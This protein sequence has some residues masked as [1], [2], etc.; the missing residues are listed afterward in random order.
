VWWGVLGGVAFVLLARFFEAMWYMLAG[1][2]TGVDRSYHQWLALACWTGLPQVVALAAAVPVLLVATTTQMDPGVISP[3]SLNEL[4]FHRPLG[5]PLHDYLSG[6]N[7]MHAVGLALA[8]YGVRCWSHRSRV[9]A[10]V[11]VLLPP[12]VIYGT[13]GWVALG[14]A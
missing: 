8:V 1:K 11:F 4:F 14:H 12:L 5:D 13:W 2:L 3:L 7:L 9:F 6:I 10:S